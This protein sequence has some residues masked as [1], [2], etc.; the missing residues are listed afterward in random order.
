MRKYAKHLISLILFVAGLAHFI[1]PE[2]FAGSIPE[3]IG[4]PYFWVYFT[5][6]IELISIYGLWS[7]RYNLATVYMLMIYFLALLPA[8]FEMVISEATIFGIS[9]KTF[10]IF[11]IFL[12]IIPVFLAYWSIDKKKHGDGL[13]S[14]LHSKISKNFTGKNAWLYKWM[15]AAAF[16]NVGWGFWVVIFPEQ[17]FRLFALDIP[18]DIYIWQSVGMIVGVYGIVYY[19]SALDL[20]KYYPILLVGMLGKIFGPLGF[21]QHY[22]MGTIQLEFGTLLLF[23]DIMWWPAFMTATVKFY[24]PFVEYIKNH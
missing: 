11:R 2:E 12:Q 1:F 23:N 18:S 10:F 9:D 22:S 19:I 5:G 24:K 3:Q 8:H 16:Y 20:V 15:F 14:N 17:A 13:L 4:M 21:I 7:K 6:V